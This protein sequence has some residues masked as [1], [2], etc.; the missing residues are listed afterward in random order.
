M[1]YLLTLLLSCNAF[2][3]GKVAHTEFHDGERRTYF[4]YE[5]VLTGSIKFYGFH[6]YSN[7]DKDFNENYLKY[8]NKRVSG[9]LVYEYKSGAESK[10]GVRIEYRLWD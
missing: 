8:E 10:T 7:V 1:K 2:G 4:Q 6:Q 3:Y 5:E 9:G